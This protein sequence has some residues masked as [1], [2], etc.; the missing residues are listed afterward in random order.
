MTAFDYSG[1]ELQEEYHDELEEIYR[2]FIECLEACELDINQILKRS[3]DELS[4]HER[5]LLRELVLRV[6]SI[7]ETFENE[8]EVD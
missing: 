8:L 6:R 4:S 7:I 5:C 2:P 1:D 3:G